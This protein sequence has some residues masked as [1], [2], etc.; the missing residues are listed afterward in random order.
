MLTEP[1]TSNAAE[2]ARFLI[3]RTGRGALGTL[4]ED[5]TPYVSLVEFVCDGGGAP[6]T[7]ISDLAQHTMNLRRAPSASL[8]VDGSG[9]TLDGPRV[10]LVGTMRPIE[11][12]ALADRF[13]AQHSSAATYAGF[14]DFGLWRLAVEKAHLVSG[15]GRIAWIDGAALLLPDAA[16]TALAEAE[17]GIVSHMNEDHADAI[18]LYAT[19]LKGASPGDWRMTGIDP[20]GFDIA[21]GTRRLRLTF[22]TFVGSSQEA[23]T[24]LVDLVKR[25]RVAST[26]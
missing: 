7:L 24:A 4:M 12:A 10:T 16:W 18:S 23:R 14:A 17:S 8:L 13:V 3:R 15:F 11:A 19:V 2:A 1:A 6:V 25:A 20:E 22:D 21:D 26:S 9:G 5:G